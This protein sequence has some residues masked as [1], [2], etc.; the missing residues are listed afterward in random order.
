MALA[1]RL[2]R[3][4]FTAQRQVDLKDNPSADGRARLRVQEVAQSSGDPG[5]PRT[6]SPGFAVP[7]I[8]TPDNV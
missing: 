4:Q 7:R 1:A 5:F 8:F 2:P 6:V 3:T